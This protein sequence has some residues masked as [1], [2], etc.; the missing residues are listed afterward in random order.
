VGVVKDFHNYSFKGGI[1]PVCISP[2]YSRY[3]YCAVKLNMARAGSLLPAMERLWNDTYPEYNYT[4]TFMDDSIA[5]FYQTETVLLR[6]IEIFAGI[7]IFIGCLGL[8]GMVSFMAVQK[9]K[10]IGVRKVLG[11][12]VPDILWIF[13]KEFFRLLIIAF[14]IAAPIGGWFM[15]RWLQDFVYRIPLNAEVFLLAL[16]STIVIAT[17]TIGYR[18]VRSALA[19]PVKSLRTE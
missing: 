15:H 5:A 12:G 7:A 4:Y 19:N 3:S 14:L 2:D 10:E 13:G 11:A 18:T 1:S 6:L 9:T 17:L 8:Y 16:A